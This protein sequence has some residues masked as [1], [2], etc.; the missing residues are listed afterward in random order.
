MFEHIFYD[1]LNIKASQDN[2]E[3]S[4]ATEV[5]KRIRRDNPTM[6]SY[7]NPNVVDF[8]NPESVARMQNPILNPYGTYNPYANPNIRPPTNTPTQNIGYSTYVNPNIYNQQYYGY[9]PGYNMDN[10]SAADT[11]KF[12][13]PD[14]SNKRIP[15]GKC[16]KP[17]PPKPS[18]YDG[19]TYTERKLL[20]IPVA[21]VKGGIKKQKHQRQ[22]RV[23][24]RKIE[25][26]PNRPY[27]DEELAPANNIVKFFVDTPLDWSQEDAKE[28]VELLDKIYV[29]DIAL[30]MIVGE[31]VIDRE[32]S[33]FNE[34][35]REKYERMMQYLSNK[36]EEYKKNEQSFRNII[37]YRAPY[38]YRE[39]PLYQVNDEGDYIFPIQEESIA[40]ISKDKITGEKVYQYDRGRDWLTEEEW[41]IF[42]FRAFRDMER[43]I[44]KILA[45]EMME[46]NKH[47]DSSIPEPTKEPELPPYNPF[48]NIS[49]KLHNL[50]KSEKEYNNHKKF[51]RYI[52]RHTMNDEEFDNW[53]Y[54]TNTQQNSPVIN[55]SS[56]QMWANDMHKRH[57]QFL[58]TLQPVNYAQQGAIC[59][60]MMIQRL[61]EYDK[62]LEKPDMS[63][64]DCM[65]LLGYLGVVRPHELNLEKQIRERAAQ[66]RQTISHNNFMKS[67]YHNVNNT[68]KNP[69]PNYVPKYGSIDPR[70]G[71]PEHYV[72]LT[73]NEEIQR[74]ANIVYQSAYNMGRQ[75]RL[76]T[77]YK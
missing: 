25:Y 68:A 4:R 39:L 77:L 65:A 62:G 2:I 46:L 50:R 24:H 75:P 17:R 20:P 33:G 9:R 76:H 38:R 41:E 47:L 52:L 57:L 69:N 70:Y 14:P 49:V 74:T 11:A 15:I 5:N 6:L 26:I 60:Q 35:S 40:K 44:E 56:Q 34:F 3:T 32:T 28:L 48:D 55:Q 42:K 29:Y 58:Q 63:L 12:M 16:G 31:F 13:I 64:P 66:N 72:D 18:K 43:G 1:A 36:L 19:L 54:G 22:I 53:W 45:I 21:V 59:R 37:D 27:T 61:R 67:M 71:M 7:H 51:F 8:S 30:A 23:E 73:N 10:L